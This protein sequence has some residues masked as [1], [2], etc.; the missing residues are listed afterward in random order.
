MRYII[1]KNGNIV[2]TVNAL[3]DL[4][5]LVGFTKQHYYHTQVNNKMTYKKDDYEVVDVVDLFYKLNPYY[6]KQN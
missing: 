2:G 5:N 1:K 6:L 3:E 4:K